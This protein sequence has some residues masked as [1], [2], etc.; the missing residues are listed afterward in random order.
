MYFSTMKHLS[1]SSLLRSR[2]RFFALYSTALLLLLTI[3]ISCNAV[4]GEE[5]WIKGRNHVGGVPGWFAKEVSAWYQT[6][7]STSVVAMIFMGDA[8]LVSLPIDPF[9]SPRLTNEVMKPVTSI[10]RDLEW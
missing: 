5:M 9:T 8:L 6:L 3:D 2:R 4:W 10:V 7:G 1:R